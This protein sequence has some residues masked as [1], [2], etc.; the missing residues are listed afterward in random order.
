M[1]RRAS[2]N[3]AMS[4]KQKKEDCLEHV[5]LASLVPHVSPGSDVEHHAYLPATA[6]LLELV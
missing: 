4:E 3:G 1:K 2:E 5:A 6:C